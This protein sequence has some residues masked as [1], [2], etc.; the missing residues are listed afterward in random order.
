MDGHGNIRLVL[1]L[2]ISFHIFIFLIF[3]PSL[4]SSL[5]DNSLKYKYNENNSEIEIE[6]E[7]EASFRLVRFQPRHVHI[8]YGGRERN[9]GNP[10]F[11]SV[12]MLKIPLGLNPGN[13]IPILPVS[14]SPTFMNL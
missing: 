12:L 13:S 3:N 6:S 14:R 2:K 9:F 10:V 4:V 8:S 7:L 1:A 11:N 5:E